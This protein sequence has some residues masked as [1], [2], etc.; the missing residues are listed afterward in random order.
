M[1]NT[2][3]NQISALARFFSSSVINEMAKNGNSPLLTKLISESNIIN[4]L[5]GDFLISDL[6]ESAFSI[7]KLRRNRNEYIYKAALT[8]KILLGVHSLKTASMMTEFRV[9]KCIADLVILNGTSTVYEIK[10]ER[11]N[12]SKLETQVKEY[13]KIFAKVNVIVGENHLK[14]V[15]NILPNEIG[16]SVLSDRH[17]ISTFR[18]ATENAKRTNTEDI[19]EAI[20]LKEVKLILEGYGEIIPKIPNTKL[21]KVLRELFL[22]LDSESAHIGM[23]NVLKQ[24]RNLVSLQDLVDE[25]PA[26]LQVAILSSSIRKQDF[27]N[28][29]SAINTPINDAIT[30]A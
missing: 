10:S 6:Y 2:K 13:M 3:E 1:R 26:S 14:N 24:T 22:Q 20:Q 19:F 7:L 27:G 25:L 15:K 16:I 23:V 28:L 30:W 8:N 18:D 12:L 29:I 9:G 4:D 5:S 17:Q 21:Y 11:D